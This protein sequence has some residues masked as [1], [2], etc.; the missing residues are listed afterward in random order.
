MSSLGAC[1]ERWRS[2]ARDSKGGVETGDD[3]E[4]FAET[5]GELGRPRARKNSKK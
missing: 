5:D 2:R 1:N 3:A 4:K